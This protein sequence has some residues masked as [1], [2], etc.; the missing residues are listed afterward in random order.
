MFDSLGTVA[1]N[2]LYGVVIVPVLVMLIGL[3][4]GRSIAVMQEIGQSA[5]LMVLASVTVGALAVALGAVGDASL[6]PVWAAASITAGLALVNSAV[7]LM[8]SPLEE[9]PQAKGRSGTEEE[10]PQAAGG[11]GAEIET[12]GEGGG[13][14][15][16][17][18]ATCTPRI[19]LDPGL[20]QDWFERGDT[21]ILSWALPA[22]G[23]KYVMYIRFTVQPSS[24][25]V[26]ARS[27]AKF[28]PW[29]KWFVGSP[30]IIRDAEATARG[31]VT[32][33]IA[34]GG[35]VISGLGNQDTESDVECSAA[36]VV[37][38]VP[39]PDPQKM[40]LSATGAVTMSGQQ[41]LAGITLQ[42]QVSTSGTTSGST[43]VPAPGGG[44]TTAGTSS[45]T[46]AQL[47][48]TAT[49]LMPRIVD[50][51]KKLNRPIMYKCELLSEEGTSGQV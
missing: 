9:T 20:A 43:S 24:L 19:F 13:S 47:T 41:A 27:W 16:R 25:L 49:I 22:N 31:V 32:C 12:R 50:K 23:Y 29:Y 11:S 46:G 28:R 35:C 39:Q 21:G 37:N 38:A 4:R 6:G 36:A 48:G 7:F 33:E 18:G 5:V 8:A 30:T 26:K 14:R 45:T 42:G 17:G 44:G 2:L 34:Q 51:K 3:A 10:T 15:S 1:E 40:L